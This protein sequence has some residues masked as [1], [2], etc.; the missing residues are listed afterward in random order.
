MLSIAI[1]SGSSPSCTPAPHL[2]PRIDY[3]RPGGGFPPAVPRAAPAIPSRPPAGYSPPTLGIASTQHPW[4]PGVPERRWTSI[5]LHHTA[6]DHGS[7]EAINESHLKKKWLGI[8]YHF[9]IGNGSGMAD[10]AIE[11]TFRWREQMHGA[12]A[13]DDEY[14]Q[15]GI[16]VALVGDFEAGRP[17][18]AQLE[19]V[20]QLV[21]TLRAAY[22][23]PVDRVLGHSDVKA[24]ACP[25]RHFPLA[26][27]S[28]SLLPQYHSPSAHSGS[29][30]P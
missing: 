13:G 1:I 7:V 11:P 18:P 17:S 19:A 6:T 14:N 21:G 16:G 22:G 12:H 29:N 30:H 4:K 5:V 26:E 20:K 3:A 10:G 28:R 9:V 25:G 8:G 23:I 15:H 27:V 24:T 2:P